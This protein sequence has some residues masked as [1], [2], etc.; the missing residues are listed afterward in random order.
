ML[1]HLM[2]VTS[3]MDRKSTVSQ[4]RRVLAKEIKGDIEVDRTTSTSTLPEE[5]TVSVN[6]LCILV[7]HS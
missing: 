3:E 2:P 6:N 1:S 4:P 5:E 7:G